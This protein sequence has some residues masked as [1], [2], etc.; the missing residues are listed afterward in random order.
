MADPFGSEIVVAAVAVRAV[1]AGLED[2]LAAAALRYMADGRAIGKVV[3]DV[4]APRSW[5]SSGSS[6]PS[7]RTGRG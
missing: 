6:G 5:G 3:L 7:G 2:H 4:T 1:P